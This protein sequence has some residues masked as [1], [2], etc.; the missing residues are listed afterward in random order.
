MAISPVLCLAVQLPLRAISSPNQLHESSL[1]A[2]LVSSV[3]RVLLLTRADGAAI[4][5]EDGRG[6][7]CRASTGEIAPPIGTPIDSRSGLT[8]ACLRSGSLMRYDSKDSDPVV[9][10]ENC[11]RLGIASIVAV[12]IVL[13]RRVAGLLEVFSRQ[14]C[15]FD[16]SDCNRIETVATTLA[17]S[18]IRSG[19]LCSADNGDPE[20]VPKTESGSRTTETQRG[21][22]KTAIALAMPSLGND[23]VVSATH[24]QTSITALSPAGYKFSLRDKIVLHPRATMWSAGALLLAAVVWFGIGFPRQFRNPSAPQIVVNPQTQ[25]LGTSP[26]ANRPGDV[27]ASTV[28]PA[29]GW[30][31]DT[32]RRAERGDPDAELKLGAAYAD[33]QNGA[34]DYSEAV[35][36]LTKSAD[37]GSVTAAAVLGAFD[38]AGRGA[39][40]GYIDAYMWSAIAQAEGDE[41]SSYRVAILESRMSPAELAE[42]RRRAVAW[43]RTHGKSNETKPVMST[44]R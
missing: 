26:T 10:R 8:G 18:M 40:P 9:D 22:T 29:P 41:A 16:I 14:S 23:T 25:R 15:A 33:G 37:H 28:S 13:G 20:F 19:W 31:E 44:N 42:G 30:L 4:A 34:A 27:S 12:P 3:E 21:P 39:T 43:L 32:R 6:M 17:D 2:L 35:K 11:R 5:L 24:D 1:D 7:C 38:W 36:W